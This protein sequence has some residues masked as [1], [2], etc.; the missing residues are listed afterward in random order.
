LYHG[1]RDY[2]PRTSV[3]QSPDPI[4][5]AYLDGKTNNGVYNPRNL[6]LYTYTHNNPVNLVDP[7]GE[8]PKLLFDFAVNIAIAYAT[9]GKLTWSAVRG[10]AVDTVTDAFNPAAQLNKGHL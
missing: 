10:A 6:H 2:D 8:N 1:V 5:N 4:L 3:W 9:E 7:D